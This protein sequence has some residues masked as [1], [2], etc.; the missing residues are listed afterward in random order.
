MNTHYYNLRKHFSF[1]ELL[2]SFSITR[3]S[4]IIMLSLYISILIC[5]IDY[6]S[7]ILF[8]LIVYTSNVIYVVFAIFYLNVI[9][10]NSPLLVHPFS[11]LIDILFRSIE[12]S[13][14]SFIHTIL[15]LLL[16]YKYTYTCTCT[17]MCTHLFITTMLFLTICIHVHA[18][19]TLTCLYSSSCIW[20]ISYIIYSQCYN[21]IIQNCIYTIEPSY[22]TLY[23]LHYSFI[24]HEYFCISSFICIYSLYG[25]SL[26]VPLILI[27]VYM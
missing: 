3:I 20:L 14:S 12:H 22:S 7:L 21:T 17:S 23:L 15:I 25:M 26:H 18:Q 9:S 24:P 10:I 2:S 5:T 13:N 8:T 6:F 19:I 1:F 16:D 4:Y 27:Y 11:P